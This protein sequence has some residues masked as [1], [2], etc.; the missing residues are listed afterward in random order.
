[1]VEG[2]RADES[3]PSGKWVMEVTP[4]RF[5]RQSSALYRLLSRPERA[6]NPFKI[7]GHFVRSE[8]RTKM[9]VI[10]HGI[11]LLNTHMQALRQS[12]GFDKEKKDEIS[13]KHNGEGKRAEKA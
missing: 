9:T 11:V 5:A 4:G 10:C 6:T 1:V 2:K 8:A 3:G 13:C 12:R 7:S